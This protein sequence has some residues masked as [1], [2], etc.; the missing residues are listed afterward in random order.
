M[1]E[2]RQSGQLQAPAEREDDVLT[3]NDWLYTNV[4]FIV[5]CRANPLR[6]AQ[7]MV[8]PVFLYDYTHT[9]YPESAFFHSHVIIV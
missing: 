9:L 6:H 3:K 4:P 8:L 7:M 1:V 2:G 5:V